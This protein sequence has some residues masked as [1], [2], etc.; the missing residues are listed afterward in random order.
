MRCTIR[1]RNG[2]P[3]QPKNLR[4][5]RLDRLLKQ[6]AE[7][8]YY[9]RRRVGLPACA[10][11][12]E[13]HL[14]SLLEK[15][16][17]VVLEIFLR[18]PA[19]FYN[20]QGGAVRPP[21]L[22][23]PLERMGRIALL[24]DPVE[25]AE[26]VCSFNYLTLEDLEEYRPAGLAG[27]V[28]RLVWLAREVLNEKVRLDSLCTAVIAF[29]GLRHGCLNAADR[30]LLWRAFQVPLF[31][32]FRGFSRELLAAECDAHDGL[33]IRSDNAIFE[34]ASPDGEA[35]LTCLDCSDYTLLR[36]GTEMSARLETAV[37]GCG[38]STPRLVEVRDRPARQR[39]HAVTPG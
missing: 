26:D 12:D 35:L 27:P 17:P 2:T 14:P 5:E 30:D 15:I 11:R 16:P 24:G 36:M 21:R 33:H 39:R 6:A 8:G 20:W 32:Q 19:E 38:D 10:P 3:A 28:S 7:C 37:C 22:E 23:R 13:R 9:R 34:T 25:E 31:E 18:N 1:W 4:L 29:T